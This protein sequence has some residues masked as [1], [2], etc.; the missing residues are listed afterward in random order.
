MFVLLSSL[1]VL[2]LPVQG[3][4]ASRAVPALEQALRG[5]I[6]DAVTGAPV[7]GVECELW[8]E[9]FDRPA[10][11]VEAAR[12][13]SDGVYELRRAFTEECK[14]RLRHPRYAGTTIAAEAG[15]D[16]EEL[17]Y[18][19]PRQEP[20]VLRI[21]DLDGN[22]V[23]HARVRSHQ[24]CRHAPPAV[25]AVGDAQGRVVLADA[26]PRAH[27]EYEVRAPGFGALVPV[28][29]DSLWPEDTLY[30]PRRAPVA[31]RLCDAQGAPLAHRRFQQQGPGPTAVVTDAAGRAVLDSLYESR[32][33][34][35]R[36]CAKELA[37]MWAWPPLV[38]ECV[39]VPG[40]ELEEPG[41]EAWPVLRV[42]GGEPYAS[43]HVQF[44]E[45]SVTRELDTKPARPI[46]VRVRPD[47]PVVVLTQGREVRRARL[48]PWSG[49][50]ELDLAD[51]ATLLVPRAPPGEPVALA[52]RVE[53]PEGQPL[54]VEA[55]LG[56][57]SDAPID[58]DPSP[59]GVLFH[60]PRGSRYEIRF[61]AEG[62]L[63]LVRLGRAY[64]PLPGPELVRL[65]R[66]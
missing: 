17:V 38:G 61:R 39:L 49:T 4:E 62:H 56:T 2:G 52:F 57:Y 18:L 63:A 14:L 58:E 42:V 6:V 21:L 43:L 25:E 59:A 9:D 22:P 41:R 1:L 53:T 48:A 7:A 3:S 34:G 40:R 12:S 8:T 37:S 13:G 51:P 54:A 10:R 65:P 31:L 11:L 29:L 30:L 46:E 47:Q 44:G 19:Y 16:D 32:E 23:P 45:D 35:L 64:E 20:L 27:A 5:R 28:H 33:I 36:D 26:L 50:R 55:S 60:V 15:E 66:P 24:T